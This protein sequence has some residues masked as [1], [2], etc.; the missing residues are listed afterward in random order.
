MPLTYST[1]AATSY[2]YCYSGI[3]EFILSVF[4]CI[5]MIIF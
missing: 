2:D 4:G 5:L 3:W 1:F